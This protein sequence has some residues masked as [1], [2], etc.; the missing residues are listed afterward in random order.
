MFSWWNVG[1]TFEKDALK[2]H[3]VVPG[4]YVCYTLANAFDD[5]STFMTEHY[6]ESSFRI[7]SRQSIGIGVAN[8]C[9]VYLDADF[10]CARRLDF[11]V[12]NGEVFSCFPR[13]RSLCSILVRCGVTSGEFKIAPCK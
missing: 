12:F 6:G 7:F 8:A 5:A 2:S 9:V 3:N 10:V 11:N 1:R 13:N 4:L